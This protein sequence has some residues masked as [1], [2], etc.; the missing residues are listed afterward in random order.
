MPCPFFVDGLSLQMPRAQS[1]KRGV[2][3]A[4]SSFLWPGKS[5]RPLRVLT[6]QRRFRPLQHDLSGQVKVERCNAFEITQIKSVRFR[7]ISRV[8]ISAHARHLQKGSLFFDG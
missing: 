3:L 8:S 1:K 7:G 2:K 6:H 4:G 5:G